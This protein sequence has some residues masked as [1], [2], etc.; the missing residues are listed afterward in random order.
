ML[1]V[2]RALDFA[3]LNRLREAPSLYPPL[4]HLLWL[5]HK[6]F[7]ADCL[8]AKLPSVSFSPDIFSPGKNNQTFSPLEIKI[9]T[10]SPGG[11]FL[12]WTDQTVGPHKATFEEEEIRREPRRIWTW[13]EKEKSKRCWWGSRLP[14]GRR[15]DVDGENG[16]DQC[17]RVQTEHSFRRIVTIQWSVIKVYDSWPW[18]NRYINFIK[19][20]HEYPYMYIHL[21]IA[22]LHF[23][24][25]SSLWRAVQEVS[26]LVEV[27]ALTIT[28]IRWT[29]LNQMKSTKLEKLNYYKMMWTKLSI[30]DQLCLQAWLLVMVLD[31]SGAD[32]LCRQ[33]KKALL[34]KLLNLISDKIES[35]RILDLSD[36][37]FNLFEAKTVIDEKWGR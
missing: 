27:N 26:S 3:T 7:N 21:W 23:Q 15:L 33:S 31:C 29:Q 36:C 4:K 1:K 6:D 16:S 11:G 8:P 35:H 37:K 13:V 14:G 28:L 12:P 24:A 34:I 32:L 19:S 18:S 25:S 22:D 9:Q 20:I 10:F 5:R 2:E 30:W 17:E